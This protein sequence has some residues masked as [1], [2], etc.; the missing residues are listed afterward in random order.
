M[1]V[2]LCFVA[3]APIAPPGA[4]VSAAEPPP[5]AAANVSALVTASAAGDAV[6]SAALLQEVLA[7]VR[8]LRGRV[9]ELA[10]APAPDARAPLKPRTPAARRPPLPTLPTLSSS[11]RRQS[12]LAAAAGQSLL[13]FRPAV[14]MPAAASG[15]GS[16]LLAG[17]ESLVHGAVGNATASLLA[18]PG[19]SPATLLA[20][21]TADPTCTPTDGTAKSTTKYPCACG[22]ETCT[23]GGKCNDGKCEYAE[24]SNQNGMPSK[25]PCA[26]GE[27]AAAETCTDNQKCTAATS[28]KC[29]TDTCSQT[30]G[31]TLSEAYPCKCGTGDKAATCTNNQVCTGTGSGQCAN[32]QHSAP[33]TGLLLGILFVAPLFSV[34][35]EG[36]CRQPLEPAPFA[37]TRAASLTR[38]LA[39]RRSWIC[40]RRQRCRKRSS[41]LDRRKNPGG[42]KR[43]P[44]GCI[45]RT[46]FSFGCPSSSRP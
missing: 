27:G 33:L 46:T 4:N 15:P 8:Q 18:R 5:P 35:L 40:S 39:A 1:L 7:E 38:R 3:G 6:N 30:N 43:T 19:Y 22:K 32:A 44:C 17:L 36:V 16:T 11:S 9:E 2:A 41:R 37:Y 42:R 26:C 10:Q 25:F 13:A 24:C 28:E 31:L 14:L 34:T 29:A 12:S 23:E 45:W 20:A 21:K